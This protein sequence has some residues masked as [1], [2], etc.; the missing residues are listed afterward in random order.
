MLAMMWPTHSHLG[1]GHPDAWPLLPRSSV[2]R[3][4]LAHDFGSHAL[5]FEPFRDALHRGVGPFSDLSGIGALDLS[6][7]DGKYI[8]TSAL[9]GVRK[10]HIR[11]ELV[12]NRHLRLRVCYKE[13]EREEETDTQ[14][15]DILSRPPSCESACT[16]STPAEPQVSPPPPTLKDD[17][18]KPPATPPSLLPEMITAEHTSAP[19]S[20]EATTATAAATAATPAAGDGRNLSPKTESVVVMERSVTLPQLVDNKGITSDYSN[21]LLRVEI[22]IKPPSYDSDQAKGQRVLVEKLQQEAADAEAK[23]AGLKKQMYEQQAKA[24]AALSAM[25]EAQS[26]MQRAIKKR[27]FSLPVSAN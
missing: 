8:I 10:D 16:S 23:V 4:H 19:A 18:K 13:S 6:Q 11:L 20:A 22:P 21:G 15:L 27:R 9:P 2:F 26:E 24:A 17:N 1:H 14:A 5:D 25:R 3:R 7:Q 12:G